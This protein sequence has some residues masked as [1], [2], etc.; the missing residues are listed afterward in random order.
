MIVD[1]K[2]LEGTNFEMTTRGD[3]VT[4]NLYYGRPAV[5]F[6]LVAAGDKASLVRVHETTTLSFRTRRTER[7]ARALS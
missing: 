7:R 6:R 4:V 2:P 5:S 3:V 1:R